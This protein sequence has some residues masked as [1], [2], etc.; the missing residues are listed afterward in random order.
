MTSE[1]LADIRAYVAQ[2]AAAR[3]RGEHIDSDERREAALLEAL[4]EATRQATKA[5]VGYEAAVRDLLAE[6]DRVLDVERVLEDVGC[7]CACDHTR[8]HEAHDE[9]CDVCVVCRVADALWPEV[10]R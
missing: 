10:R 3:A 7:D 6:I 1:E 5:R 4:D 8:L 9:D 2:R